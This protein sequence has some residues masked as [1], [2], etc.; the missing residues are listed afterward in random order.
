MRAWEKLKK[1][2]S[3]GDG[4]DAEKKLRSQKLSLDKVATEKTSA[5][6]EHLAYVG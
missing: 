6:A 2:L 5:V 3:L 1:K 4:L